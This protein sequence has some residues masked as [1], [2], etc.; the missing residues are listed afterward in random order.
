M[1]EEAFSQLPECLEVRE[2]AL[3]LHR[4]GFRDQWIIIVTTLLDAKCYST[5]QL[6]QLYGGL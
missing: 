3:L 2:V 6:G 5:Q 1:S 4:P